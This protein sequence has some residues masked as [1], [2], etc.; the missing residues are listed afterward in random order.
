[1]HLHEHSQLRIKE[2]SLTLA[3]VFVA[4]APLPSFEFTVRVFAVNHGLQRSP[5]TKMLMMLKVLTHKILST[6]SI[7]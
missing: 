1:M 2:E 5:G 7:M 6:L 3:P 4:E